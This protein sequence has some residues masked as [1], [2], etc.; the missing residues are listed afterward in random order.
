MRFLFYATVGMSYL[1][2]L[3]WQRASFVW[4][5]SHLPSYLG[6]TLGQLIHLFILLVV[7]SLTVFG[8]FV[9]LV[10]SLWSIGS[11][12]T[13][14]ETWEI[15]RHATLVRRARVLGGYLEGPGGI[16]VH[17][18]KQEYPYDIGIWANIKQSMGGSANFI[19]WFWPLA[20]TPDRQTGWAFETNDFEDPGVSWPPP[21]PDRIPIPASARPSRNIS[22]PTYATIQDEIDAFNRRK[23]EDMKRFQKSPGLQRR[24]PFHDR[25]KKDDSAQSDSDESETDSEGDS[26]GEEAWRNAEGE[27]LRDFGVD[28]EA[29]F[30]DEE[31][32]PLGVLIERRRQQQSAN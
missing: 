16:R 19:S 12:T 21:D 30:Y 11:N 29:E 14:I 9:L 24:K 3:L 1:E 5:N 10:R 26:E 15:E 18:K 13:T 25:Y 20:A 17:I 4:K 28:E 31:D 23:Q 2:T 22:M 32:I 27:R 8:L 6:P 7:N